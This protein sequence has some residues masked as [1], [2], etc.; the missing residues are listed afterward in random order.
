[1]SS[2]PEPAPRLSLVIPTLNEAA[3]IVAFLDALLAVTAGMGEVEVL[4][5][6]DASGDGTAAL[7]RER[8]G[9]AGRV[10]ERRGPR[11][12]AW[13]VIEGW[14]RARGAVLGVM[15]ADLSHPPELLPRLLG[16]IEAGGVDVALASRY[17][18]GGGTE[19]WPRR[20]QLTS[21]FA[22]SLA[23]SLVSVQ[24]PL[25]GYLLF[26]REVIE[27]VALHPIGWKIALEVLVRG[28]YAGVAEVPFVFRDR[29]YG[30][31]KLCSRVVLDYLRHLGRLR[32]HMLRKGRLRR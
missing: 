29:A 31:S 25:S 11:S 23:R 28:R 32:L 13:S 7:A 3:G 10:I 14:E 17:A 24:D 8:L 19:G 9:D 21:R 30:A 6:D 26:R 18:R 20:R 12:L 16:E 4:V 1:M 5:V 27:G 15:D 22:S 2:V